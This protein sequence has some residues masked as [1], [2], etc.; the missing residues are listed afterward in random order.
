M[1]TT[2]TDGNPISQA[3]A[4]AMAEPS[5]MYSMKLFRNGSDL[6]AV[7]KRAKLDLGAGQLSDDL[8]NKWSINGKKLFL[9]F[10]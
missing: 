4:A 1:I 8:G 9:L 7:I 6:G 10:S 5:V 2:N 3:F